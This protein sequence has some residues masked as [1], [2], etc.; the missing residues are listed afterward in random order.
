[1]ALDRLGGVDRDLVVGAVPLGDGQV[2]VVQVDVEVGQDQLVLD[3]APHDAS[4]LV[5]VELDDG[6]GDLDPCCPHLGHRNL[7]AL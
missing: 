4:H 3:E 6:V 7:F 1:M 2:V 5:A